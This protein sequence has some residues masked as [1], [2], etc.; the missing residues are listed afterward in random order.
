MTELPFIAVES[1]TPALTRVF[2]LTHIPIFATTMAPSSSRL[3]ALAA[4]LTGVLAQAPA[5]GDDGKY[6]IAS[7]GIR[8]QVKQFPRRHS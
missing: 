2:Y 8:A 5:P 1:V 4:T 3:V 7:D 6:T